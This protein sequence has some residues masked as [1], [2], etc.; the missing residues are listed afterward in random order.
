MG[1]QYFPLD[2]INTRSSW[3]KHKSNVGIIFIVAF[4]F[5]Y[6]GSYLLLSVDHVKDNTNVKMSETFEGLLNLF[7]ILT[8]AANMV[9]SLMKTSKT[10][11]IFANLE[12]ISIILSKYFNVNVD[13][14]SVGRE[15]K[16]FSFLIFSIFISVSFAAIILIYQLSSFDM[17]LYFIFEIFLYCFIEVAYY[18]FVFYLILIKF[19]TEKLAECVRHFQ[20]CKHEVILVE[21]FTWSQSTLQKNNREFASLETALALKK[22]Y[23]IIFR[24]ASLINHICGFTN[25]VGIVSIINANVVGGYNLY[26]AVKQDIPVFLIIGEKYYFLVSNADCYDLSYLQNHFTRCFCPSSY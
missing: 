9:Y 19:N 12:K 18:R 10:K 1:L 5:A 23:G 8:I 21:K 26:L 24:T 2:D 7:M 20:N 13:Y 6:A 25:I 15:C 17:F 22:V 4:L 16:I 11:E 3:K 14:A